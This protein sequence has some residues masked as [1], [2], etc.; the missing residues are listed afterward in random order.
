MPVWLRSDE[1]WRPAID[2]RSGGT[3][4]TPHPR[5]TRMDH[6]SC[7][8]LKHETNRRRLGEICRI[9]NLDPRISRWL[10]RSGKLCWAVNVLYGRRASGKGTY[11]AGI[12]LTGLS[13]SRAKRAFQLDLDALVQFFCVP[14]SRNDRPVS[15]EFRTFAPSPRSWKVQP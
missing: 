9:V 8:P 5:S 4:S 14:R 15:A 10:S 3:A 2:L 11:G 13:S 1:R 6:P 12:P 7:G